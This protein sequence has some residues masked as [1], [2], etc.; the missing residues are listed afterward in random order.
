MKK[1]YSV[2]FALLLLLNLNS[3]INCSLTYVTT[4]QNF[5]SYIHTPSGVTL[6]RAKMYIDADGS[7]RAYGPNNSG[8]DWTANAGSTGNWWGIVTDSNGDPI[9][10]NSNDPYPGMYVSTTSLVNSAYGTTNPLHY[11][12]SE[13][14]PFIVLPSSVR[15]AGN[16]SIGDVAYVYNT[17][18]GKSCFAI[19]ADAGPSSSLG[20]GSMFL[21]D[22]IGIGSNPKTGG[23]SLGIID[24]VVF[25][26]SGFGQGK[27][28]T[29]A[30]I[31]SIGNLKLNAANV[32]GPCIVK[33]IGPVYD[34]VSPATTI[35]IPAASYDTTNFTSSFTDYDSGCFGIE[36]SFYQV[37]NYNTNNEWRANSSRG[38][39]ND[40]FNSGAINTE[41]TASS[42]TW[43]L[44]AG[45]YLQQLDESVTNT[46]IYS[47]LTQNLSDAYLYS[48]KGTLG[49]TGTSRRAGFHFFADQPDSSNRGNSYFVWFRLDNDKIQIYE[50]INNSWGSSPVKDTTFNFTANQSYDFKVLYNRITGL[51]RVYVDGIKS[52]EWTDSNPLANGS[53]ISFRS[54]N[55]TYKID[56]FNV[57]RSRNQNETINVGAGNTNDL[58]YENQNPSM[59]AGKINSVVIDGSANLSSVASQTVNVDFSSPAAVASINDGGSGDIDTTTNGT[60]LKANWNAATDV[61][62]GIAQYY[63]AIGTTAGASDVVGWTNNGTATSITINGLTLVNMQK[64]FVSV[65]AEN[66]AQMKSSVSISDGQVYEDITLGVSLH[67]NSNDA[68]VFN[69]YPNPSA[70]NFTVSC[71]SSDIKNCKA[72]VVNPLGEKIYETTFEKSGEVKIDVSNHSNGLYYVIV[73]GEGVHYCKKILVGK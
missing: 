17:T 19:Y 7:P 69:V 47:P 48:W 12:N 73:T 14:V 68:I 33:C 21:A 59:F 62:S 20:E 57:F 72:S 71:N 42:G 24:Y 32:G 61:N 63:Y 30:Q 28:P 9:L 11:T 31:D 41:W 27:I 46:N 26:Q 10:Q 39:F 6:Y 34:T 40:D 60:Q 23:T 13:T 38:F 29:I 4:L 66:G 70:G 67:Q 55:C 43:T 37:C 18:N 65:Q 45:N 35:T 1:I 16:I 49:G 25:P 15:T 54:A 36:K 53:Y 22:Q 44:N 52:A 58:R 5:N 3:Q 64:Y 50:V 2:A 56:D 51:I 8:L